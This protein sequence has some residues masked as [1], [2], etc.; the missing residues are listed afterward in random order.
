MRI[1]FALGGTD[2]GR[3]GIGIYVRSVVPH[4]ARKVTESGGSF[5]AIGSPS[6]LLAYDGELNGAD[7]AVA[8][9]ACDG[10]AL[11]A[12]WYLTWAG[13]AAARA[14]ADVLLLPAAN[15]RT[16]VA[17]P[18]PTVAVVHDLAQLKVAKKYD[19][20]RMAYLRHVVLRA[21]R[22]AGR[23]VAVSRATRDDLVSALGIDARDV[24]VVL[25]GV[26]AERFVPAG[27]DDARVASA[28]RASGLEGPY[29]LYAARLEHPGK[30][31]VRLVRAFAESAVRHTHLLALAGGDW[32]ARE[33]I[34]EE[35]AQHGLQDRVRLLGYVADDVLEGLLAGADAVA[36]VGLHEGFGLPALE[37]L[38]AGRPVLASSTGA[39]PEVVGDLGALCDPLDHRAIAAALDKVVLDDAWR[40]KIAEEGPRYAAQHGWDRT[41]DGLFEACEEARSGRVA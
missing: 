1:A 21:L 33:R 14:D 35:I 34:V 31:H 13:R 3:S 16:T 26:D 19:A 6:E 27:P 18:V 39:L 11:S 9:A 7:R 37:A 5:V 32:G 12:A 36:M 10:P 25:N 4:L 40:R 38:A 24:K 23:L 20:L 30:N 15:R 2:W 28:R 8:P 17:S 29:V 41:A 22:S